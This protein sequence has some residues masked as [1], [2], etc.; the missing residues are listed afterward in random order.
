MH[1]F[2][3]T[4]YFPPEI[5]ASASRWSD[6]VE[7]LIQKNYKVTVLCEAPHY[8]Y[9]E[10]FPGFNNSWLSVEK[11]S[12]KLTILR[13]K[14]FASNRKNFI[15][16]IIHYTVFML[17]AILNFRKVKNYDLLIISSPPLFTGIIG[18]FAKF[19]FKRNYWLDIRDLWPDSVY[20]LG[21]IKKGF[22]LKLSKKL[23][24]KIYESA[25][26]FIFPVPGF[27]R[28]LKSFSSIVANKPM[29]ELMNGVSKDFINKYMSLKTSS[30]KSFTVL[31][32]GNMGLAQD[33]ETI[34]K[35]AEILKDYNI[36]FTFIGE[37]VCK[38]KIISLAGSLVTKI[39]FHNPMPR[40]ELIESINNA[41]VCVVPLKDRKLFYSALPSKIFEYMA[42][43]RPVI[44]GIKGEAKK[45]IKEANAGIAIEPEN[46]VALSRAILKYYNN[47]QKCKID[48]KNGLIYV[49]N[50]LTKEVLISNLIS[51]LKS[52]QKTI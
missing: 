33:L 14:A 10:Y 37:G 7:I 24:K 1:V 22:L 52:E 38:Q 48:G 18:L 43:E 45:M 20:E 35:A 2:I 8:P 21:Q 25:E 4:Q 31:Y 23:E 13:S 15:K 49:T 30:A 42:C 32:S 3:I 51:Q 5:G 6:F 29:Y 11:K 44:I 26:G 46:P 47:R 39:N 9:S 12:S 41:S 34:V 28:Y 27:R 16:K 19:F 40:Q 36:N 50:N 17:S